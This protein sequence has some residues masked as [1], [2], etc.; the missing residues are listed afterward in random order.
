MACEYNNSELPSIFID[1]PYPHW[2]MVDKEGARHVFYHDCDREIQNFALSRIK[3]KN[4]LP[5]RVKMNEI[6]VKNS[7][8]KSTYVLCTEDKVIN[9]ASQRDIATRF[10]LNPEQII[11]FKSGHS[12]FFSHPEALATLITKRIRGNE[13]SL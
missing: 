11:S 1:A 12:P 13:P 5:D 7:I 8:D 6:V 10:G 3:P 9:P 2:T 4:G